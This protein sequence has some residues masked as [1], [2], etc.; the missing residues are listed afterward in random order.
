[1][2]KDLTVYLATKGYS[3]PNAYL[4]TTP[5]WT[6]LEVGHERSGESMTLEQVAYIAEWAA[7]AWENLSG[8]EYKPVYISERGYAA[9][10]GVITVPEPRKPKSSL[11]K[12]LRF[13]S[14][15]GR[16]KA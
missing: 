15:K 7:K 13:P 16:D 12:G 2:S 8:E 10:P 11:F 14:Q 4:T 5:G 9:D 1:M 6:G 3:G